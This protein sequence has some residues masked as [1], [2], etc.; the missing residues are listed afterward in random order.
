MKEACLVIIKPDGIIKSLTGD[1][2]SKL[3]HSE[4]KIIGAK[5]VNVNRE[6]AEAHYSNLRTEQI[7]KH[8]EE[9][10]IE[11]FE[12]VMKYI[13]GEFHTDRV[14]ALIYYGENAIK[15]IRKLAGAT[16][17]EHA[18]PVSIRGKFGRIHSQTN[19]F[20][21][22]MHASDSKEVAKKEIQLWFSPDEITE[23]I[24]PTTIKEVTMDRIM[25]KN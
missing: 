25:W 20:E 22:V 15:K 11:I 23:D 9:K 16:N 10:G 14:F 8:G 17:P 21:N 19:V 5:I 24:Y 4:L 1:I 12:S 7:A 6:V 13:Q 2:L 18:E 3:S